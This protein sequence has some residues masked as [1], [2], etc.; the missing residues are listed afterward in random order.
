[1]ACLHGGVFTRAQWTSFLG[2][3]PEK[4]R[5][6][7][8]ALVAQGL[9][10]E[11]APAAGIHGIGR[12]CRIQALKVYRALGAGE[13]FRRRRITSRDVLMRRLL[14]L[15]FPK[16]PLLDIDLR[17]RPFVRLTPQRLRR[18]GPRHDRAVGPGRQRTEK[19]PLPLEAVGD[20]F[21]QRPVDP[22]VRDLVEPPPHPGV[23][24]V[25]G[26]EA[27]GWQRRKKLMMELVAE[28]RTPFSPS[29]EEWEDFPTLPP[30]WPTNEVAP[31]INAMLA[32]FDARLWVRDYRL[33]GQDSVTW[34][35]WDIEQA[36]L[37]FTARMDAE[38]TL[39]DARGDLVLLRRLDEFDVPR[40]V[41][42][43]LRAPPD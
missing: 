16:R 15:D 20:A 14:A 10:V 33:P 34:R 12:V 28:G 37:L 27:E 30:D 7:V 8:R 43:R 1:M 39:L 13:F 23:E 42:S 6:A 25:V 40:A 31:P 41:V 26:D 29:P 3:H 22:D 21:L 19:R 36:R 18:L 17:Q 4:V 2:C 11:E 38:D 32:D 24:I 35:V 5:R 9:A